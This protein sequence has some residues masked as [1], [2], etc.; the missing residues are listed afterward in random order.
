VFD[1][2]TLF[3]LC[4]NKDGKLVSEW[5]NKEKWIEFYQALDQAKQQ[6]RKK[7]RLGGLPF[8]V[9][10]MYDLMVDS[11]KRG[12]VDEFICA[13]GCMSHYVGDACQPLHISHKYNGIIPA[14]K[15]VHGKYEDDMLTNK[16]NRKELFDGINA[17]EN[18]VTIKQLF[19][20][21]KGAAKAMLRLMKRTFD[22]LP[23]DTVIKA[24]RKSDGDLGALWKTV[25]FQT[26]ENINDG[27][28][29]M[30]IIWQSAWKEGR[31]EAIKDS[32]LKAI[33]Q[34][35]LKDL[36]TDTDFVPAFKLSELELIE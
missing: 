9:W 14:D 10:Q 23:P 34:D 33:T 8:R 32:K 16:N 2:Q 12:K 13:G 19:I 27:S 26:I 20:G 6:P 35:R 24:W 28:L 1:N 30:A 5:V 22:R 7:K 15:G 25:G 3:D 17:F 21:G 29:T 18:K 36:Y 4:F 31:G 11:L